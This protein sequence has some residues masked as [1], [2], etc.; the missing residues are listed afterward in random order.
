MCSRANACHTR[1]GVLV[2][3][4]SRTRSAS[5]HSHVLH[6]HEA[7][8]Q[9]DPSHRAVADALDTGEQGDRR[10]QI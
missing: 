3:G 1:P 6:A 10:G 4:T 2:G 9:R 5:P 7:L 8:N